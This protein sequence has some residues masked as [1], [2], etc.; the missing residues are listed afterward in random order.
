[1]STKTEHGKMAFNALEQTNQ[2]LFSN[3]ELSK[4]NKE[5]LNEFFRKQRSSGGG[6]DSTLRDYASRFNS[7][8]EHID[9]ELDQPEKRDLEDI[10][11]KFNQDLITK[12]NGEPYSDHSKAKFWKTLSVFYQS[13]IKK[14]GKGFQEDINGPELLE[15]LE[16]RISPVVK[17]N[18]DTKPVPEE[19]KQLAEAANNLRDQALIMFGWSTGCRIGEITQTQHDSDPIL[20]KHIKFKDD[21]M[22]VKISEGGKNSRGKTGERTIPVRVGMPLMRQLYEEESPSMEDPVFRKIQPTLFCPECREKAVKHTDASYDKRVYRCKSCSWKGKHNE[23][24]K[25]RQ[26]LKDDAVRRTL[27]RIYER[28][29]VTREID[30]NPH[31]IFR[32]SRALHK[33]A[34]GWTEYQLRAHFGWSE[35][36]DAPK[37]YITIVK[38]GLLAAMKKEFGDGVIDEDL[39]FNE[40]QYLKPVK[41][42]SCQEL[43]SS[44]NSYCRSCDS[45]LDREVRQH[46]KT[47]VERDAEDMKDTLV[48]MAEEMGLELDKFEELVKQHSS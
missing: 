23:A 32:K 17:V 8:A 6:G 20:W 30:T 27:E 3:P 28:S 33:A 2:K 5:V 42:R 38:Q 4:H 13:F 41:C 29:E 9:F 39:G 35:N 45:E 7:L 12:N 21:Y 14:E 22:Q 43:N 15:D 1:M 34:I 18:P 11:A 24:V 44:L 16:L 26:P 40:D 36:S 19:V 46:N 10:I 31:S 37:H 25:E 47:K 48:D